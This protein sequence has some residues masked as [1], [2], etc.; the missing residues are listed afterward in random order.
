MTFKVPNG[1]ATSQ[2]QQLCQIILKSS[3][4]C[5]SHD[6]NK[7]NLWPFSHLTFKYNLDFQPTWTNISKMIL[8]FLKG[9][10]LCQI[11]LNRCINA[12]VMART[13]S[14]NDSF[15]SLYLQVWLYFQPTWTNVSIGTSTPKE[16]NCA[17]LFSNP[18]I[19]VQFMAQTSS[20][21]DNFIIWHWPSTY[22][23]KGVKWHFT[24]QRKQLC[25]T[26]LKSMHK[27][28]CYGSDKSGQMHAHTTHAHRPEVVTT[29]PR[30]LQTGS[31]K[32]ESGLKGKNQLLA[33]QRFSFMNWPLLKKKAKWK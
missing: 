17:K 33:E 26:I 25:Q 31:K 21:Y 19:S 20:F 8:L 28:A 18:C 1:T 13:S 23:D 14:I 9:G 29:M 24:P 16:N 7:L 30:S 10:E 11:I 12:E 22:Q 5:R 3:H 6:P 27:C 2:G 32:M 4:K 15:I